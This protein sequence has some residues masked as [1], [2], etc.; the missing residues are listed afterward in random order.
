MKKFLVLVCSVPLCLSVALGAEKKKVEEEKVVLTPPFRGECLPP[1]ISKG[2]VVLVASHSL[3]YRGKRKAFNE[4]ALAVENESG[5]K[6]ARIVSNVNYEVDS[7]GVRIGE[8]WPMTE[9]YVWN[10]CLGRRSSLPA[11]VRGL[12]A[13]WE[14]DSLSRVRE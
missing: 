2:K 1:V 8:K 14:I 10:F 3:G 13:G 11:E 12:V 4:V 6:K 5:K 9:A 7:R